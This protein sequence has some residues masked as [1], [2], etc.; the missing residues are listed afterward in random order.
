MTFVVP[1]VAIK[2]AAYKKLGLLRGM[3]WGSGWYLPQWQADGTVT[4]P[5]NHVLEAWQ[6]LVG[7]KLAFSGLIS[8]GPWSMISGHSRAMQLCFLR[9]L[10]GAK[11]NVSN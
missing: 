10:P 11:R 7:T 6:D 2:I 5:V 9:F 1:F 8:F 3:P 4:W